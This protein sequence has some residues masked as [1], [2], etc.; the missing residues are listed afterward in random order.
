LAVDNAGGPQAERAHYME[1]IANFEQYLTRPRRIS[2]L[3]D[4]YRDLL[5]SW[6]STVGRPV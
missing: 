3:E 4:E 1:P 6:Q 2:A 5:S